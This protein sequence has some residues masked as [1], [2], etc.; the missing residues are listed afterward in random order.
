[1]FEANQF[2]GTADKT[3]ALSNTGVSSEMILNNLIMLH[4]VRLGP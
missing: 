1:M 3:S 4:F 2:S